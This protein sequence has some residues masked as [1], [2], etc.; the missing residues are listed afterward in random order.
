MLG[1]YI[2]CNGCMQLMSHNMRALKVCGFHLLLD[3]GCMQPMYILDNIKPYLRTMLHKRI[4][5]S[6]AWPLCERPQI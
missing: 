6:L 2:L 5:H 3:I 4:H 1:S